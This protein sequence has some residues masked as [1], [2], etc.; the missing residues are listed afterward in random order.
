MAYAEIPWVF[1]SSLAPAAITVSTS[2][3]S[4]LASESATDKY[5]GTLDAGKYDWSVS[6]TFPAD[7]SL[8]AADYM[9]WEWEETIHSDVVDYE[10]AI[11]SIMSR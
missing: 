4:Y 5:T 3:V 7:L 1:E 8:T 9:I 11:T 6:T 2:E 10:G